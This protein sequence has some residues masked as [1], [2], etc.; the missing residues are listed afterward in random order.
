M[1]R[2]EEAR[3]R[4]AGAAQ[5]RRTGAVSDMAGEGCRRGEA[6]V[7]WRQEHCT[8]VR[9]LSLPHARPEGVPTFGTVLSPSGWACGVL[10]RHI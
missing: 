4:P 2:I 7:G 9:Q 1:P 6:E 3:R 5:V 10:G 8:N